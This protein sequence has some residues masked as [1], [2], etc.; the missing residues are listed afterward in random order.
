MTS[1]H[2][3]APK[4]AESVIKYRGGSIFTGAVSNR[5]KPHS[6]IPS[7]GLDAEA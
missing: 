5:E 2:L 4:F 6:T 3:F 1:A 7:T